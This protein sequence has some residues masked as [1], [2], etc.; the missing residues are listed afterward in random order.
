MIY[1]VTL[2]PAIDLSL[3]VRDGLMPGSINKSFGIRTCPGGKGINVSKT[4]KVLGKDSVVCA[5]LCG[6]DGNKLLDMLKTDFEVLSISYPSGNTRTNIKITGEN[7]VTTDINGEGPLYD[8]G[9]IEQFKGLLSGR[10]KIGDIV[11]ISG[12]PP[13]GSPSDIYADLIRCFGSAE[14]VRVILDSAGKYLQEGLKA[15]PFAV[16]P[17]CEELGIQ[18][19]PDCALEEARNIVSQGISCCLISMGSDGAVFA[20]S[21][22]TSLYSKALDV[23]VCCTTGCGDAMTAGLAYA[24]GESMTPEDTF[25]LCMALASA[26]AETEGTD[27]P[28]KER[29]TGLYGEDRFCGQKEESILQT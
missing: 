24:L 20:D 21:S 13:L 9:S 17:T 22:R 25:R 7:G 18:N 10:L 6:E 29:V 1:T 12:R 23:K 14:G 8:S 15:K 5:G 2:N 26:E 11:V 16:K 28:L 27:P 3:R 19:D 4:L